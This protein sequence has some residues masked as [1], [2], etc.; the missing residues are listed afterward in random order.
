MKKMI[1]II[2]L[3][4]ILILGYYAMIFEPNNIQIERQVITIKNLPQ[5]FVGV[6]IIQ[7]S[8][9]HSLLFG[10]REKKVLKILEK[11]KP[12][13]VFITG[14]FIDPLT[15]AITDKELR[16]VEIFWQ[17]LAKKYENRIFGVLG[18]H[19][20]DIV[21]DLLKRSGIKILDNENK[22][23]F[24]DNK[25]IYLIGIDDPRTGRDNLTKAMEEIENDISKILL[26]HA[27]EIINEAVEKNID[28][29]LVGDTHGGQVNIPPFG[30]LINPILSKYGQKYTNGLFKVDFTY[31]YVNRGI[32]TSLL[33]IRFN[34]PPEITL[35][36]LQIK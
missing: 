22:K 10:F 28:L 18:N 13:F 2:F 8:D 17:K 14:D 7:L 12:D 20:T 9:L 4:G 36:E 34:C 23:I 1:L 35:I 30:R 29:V 21:K 15:K 16:S 5:S 32:G 33:P 6:K 3:F 27:P 11:L 31:L 24:I 26:A 25:F 19:D